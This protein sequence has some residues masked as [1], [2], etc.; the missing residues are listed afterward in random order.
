MRRGLAEMNRAMQ[1]ERPMWGPAVICSVRGCGR[2]ALEGTDGM[3]PD[4]AA[5]EH[6]LNEYF[7]EKQAAKRRAIAA[8]LRNTAWLLAFMAAMGWLL[9]EIWPYLWAIYELWFGDWGK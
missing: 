6:E 8:R 7:D 9:Y 2:V 5:M 4:C 1:Q 3:C